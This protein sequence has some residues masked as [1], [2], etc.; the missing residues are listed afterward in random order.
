MRKVR[1]QN[2]GPHIDCKGPCITFTFM[3][4]VTTE[5]VRFSGPWRD[6]EKSRL[7]RAVEAFEERT[8]NEEQQTLGTPWTCFC[9]VYED[10]RFFAALRVPGT[11]LYSAWTVDGLI[12]K[13]EDEEDV[14]P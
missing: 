3:N 9:A 7:L 2:P 10:R 6:E 1:V 12:T 5:L 13:I 4:V 14:R 11:Y 8:A